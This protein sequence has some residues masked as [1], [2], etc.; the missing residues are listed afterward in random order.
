MDLKVKS[1]HVAAQRLATV[2]MLRGVAALAVVLY[3]A[4]EKL[5]CG[6]SQ[7]LAETGF[8]AS[9]NAW[10]GYILS[11]FRVGW[12]GVPMFFVLSGYCIHRGYARRLQ[13]DPGIAIDWWAY[14]RRRMWRIYPVYLAALALTV[15]TDACLRTYAPS[16]HVAGDDH[17]P[18]TFLCSALSLQNILAPEF[19]SNHVFWTLSLELHFYAAYPL[20][21]VMSRRSPRRA[22]SAA[23]A[24]S[25]IYISADHLLGISARFPYRFGHGS[26]VFLTYWATWAVGMY[27]AD[28]EAGRARIPGW[29]ISLSFPAFI[30]GWILRSRSFLGFDWLCWGWSFAGLLFMLTQT[31]CIA[32]FG[33]RLCAFLSTVGVFSYSLYA[34]HACT[35]QLVGACLVNPQ[36]KPISLLPMFVGTLLCIAF[37]WLSFQCVER[38]SLR[39]AEPRSHEG[40]PAEAADR[41]TVD[42]RGAFSSKT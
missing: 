39:A 30:L 2:D 13:A 16:W 23:L 6:T 32:Y 35:L 38:W 28:V 9:P 15:A 3:H 24:A 11:I 14:A 4:R 36:A 20:L 7:L 21:L 10:A 42:P 5:W 22:C 26:P 29:V 12:L 37:A 34:T 19:G 41:E 25:L 33:G 1:T 17:S 18:L 40:S 31:R 8:P 27:L